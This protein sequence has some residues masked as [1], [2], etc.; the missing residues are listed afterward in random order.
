MTFHIQ[1]LFFP[2]Q[3]KTGKKKRKGR[4]TSH[5][6]LRLLIKRKQKLVWRD[7][8]GKYS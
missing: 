3:K 6:V 4:N 7:K 2:T 1:G 8:E 5:S